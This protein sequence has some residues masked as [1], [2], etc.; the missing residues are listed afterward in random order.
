MVMIKKEKGE[1]S[2][3]DILKKEVKVQFDGAQYSIRLPLFFVEQ[4]E[5]KK[6]QLAMIEYNRK[7]K[8]YS[9]TFNKN[10]RRKK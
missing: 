5:I 3:P 4:L 10:V 9:I 7:T 8:K 2:I 6:G 1:Y